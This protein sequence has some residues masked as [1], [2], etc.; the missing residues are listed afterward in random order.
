M[1]RFWI[2]LFLL[3]SVTVCIAG[4]TGKLAGKVKSEN[5]K[6]LA[7]VDIYVTQNNK[8]ITGTQSKE[9][10]TYMIIN[11]PPGVFDVM[12]QLQGYAGVKVTGVQIKVDATTTQNVTIPKK[13]IKL[14]NVIIPATQSKVNKDKSGQANGAVEKPVID[15]QISDELAGSAAG[16]LSLQEMSLKQYSGSSGS[17]SSYGNSFHNNRSYE[18]IVDPGVPHYIDKYGYER[19]DYDFGC[20]YFHHYM[21]PP[22]PPPIQYNTEDYAKV[23]ENAF[24][25]TLAEPL[26]TFSIDVDTACYTNIKRMIEAHQL[27]ERSYV[28][29]EEL[30]NFFK[31]DYPQPKDEHPFAVYTE[32]GSCPWN[33]KHQLLQIG[34][35]GKDIDFSKAPNSNLV[36]LLDVSGSM[37]DANKLTLVKESM[38]LLVKQLRAEDKVS[39]V[40]YSSETSVVLPS[41]SGSH[42]TTIINAI[43]QLSAGGSTA[44]GAGL[45]LAYRT[46]AQNFMQEG[47]N[48]IILCTDG[49]FN[50]GNFANEDMEKLVTQKRVEGV[51]LTVLGF[52]VG[53]IKDSKMELMADKGNGNYAYIDNLLEAHRVLVKEMGGTLFNIAKDVKLQLEFNPSKVKAYRLIGYENRIMQAEDF[54]NDKKDAG[55]LGAGHSVTA[56]Y[57]LVPGNSEEKIDDIDPLKYQKV[58]LTDEAIK[59]DELLTV[60]MRYKK[61]DADESILMTKIVNNNLISDKETSDTFRFAAAVA[62]YGLLLKDSQ[63]KADCNWRQVIE[64]ANG[65]IGKD[66]DGYRREFI[67]LSEQARDLMQNHHND[68]IDYRE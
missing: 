40:T 17:G 61:P 18:Q 28:R 50:T 4:T 23:I 54:N 7:Y 3:I 30:L 13:T 53:N 2:T 48:R 68:H 43:N 62:G 32:Q 26:S 33:S 56:L 51:Y 64:L 42:K 63:Y 45:E 60:K 11:I 36:F 10:G 16:D 1:F 66:P 65:A 20:R 14:N 59:N 15:I 22:P 49:D 52:G 67:T 44:G 38:K 55:E 21:P 8:R 41:T 37:I 25:Y 47:N 27:P 12:Y 6:A 9:N 31:Y 35:Q 24:K 57:E 19:H 34:L 5:G 29:I 58:E 46:A 39:I